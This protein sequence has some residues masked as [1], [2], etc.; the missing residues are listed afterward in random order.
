[1]SNCREADHVLA[2]L[3]IKEMF[4]FIATRDDVDNGKPSPEIY[5]LV[6]SQIDAKPDECLVIEDTPSWCESSD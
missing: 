2:I 4:D 5:L 3:E 1:M 6:A